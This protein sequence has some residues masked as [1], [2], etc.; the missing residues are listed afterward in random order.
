M[1]FAESYVGGTWRDRHLDLAHDRPRHQQPA[2]HD[3]EDP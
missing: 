2:G 3:L 1:R